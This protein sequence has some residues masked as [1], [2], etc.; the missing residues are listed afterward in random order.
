MELSKSTKHCLKEWMKRKVKWIKHT[1][2][3]FFGSIFFCTFILISCQYIYT[4]KRYIKTPKEG[5]TK[6]GRKYVQITNTIFAYHANQG[7][8]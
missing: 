5:K 6:Q 2:I 1:L 8:P 7:L 4:E 3:N